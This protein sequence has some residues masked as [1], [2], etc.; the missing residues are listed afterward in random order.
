[1]TAR[2]E[3]MPCLAQ[4]EARWDAEAKKIRYYASFEGAD[5]Q[6]QWIEV[7][8]EDF[9]RLTRLFAQEAIDAVCHQI[10]ETV[11]HVKSTLEEFSAFR[12]GFEKMARGRQEGTE[13]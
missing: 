9:D 7:A 4:V 10:Y 11:D 3:S 8:A 1:M 12:E 5:D 13:N 2:Q 6:E